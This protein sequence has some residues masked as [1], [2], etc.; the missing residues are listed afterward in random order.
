MSGGR[1]RQF[2]EE[3]ELGAETNYRFAVEGTSIN[4]RLSAGDES[5]VLQLIKQQG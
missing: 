5:S 4:H 3:N 1:R 2:L